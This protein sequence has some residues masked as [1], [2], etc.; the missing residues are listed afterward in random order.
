MNRF[1]D[2]S[3]QY[4][5]AKRVYIITRRVVSG[6]KKSNVFDRRRSLKPRVVG[7]G[8]PRCRAGNLYLYNVRDM[9]LQRL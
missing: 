5:L 1:R 8:L 9:T 3:L 6:E 7:F 2:K 4:L